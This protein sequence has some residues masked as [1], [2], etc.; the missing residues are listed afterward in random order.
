LFRFA[1][2][3]Y[4]NAFNL[5]LPATTTTAYVCVYKTDNR[6]RDMTGNV[7]VS[8]VA[9]A[10]HTNRPVKLLLVSGRSRCLFLCSRSCVCVCV[11]VYHNSIIIIYIYVLIY[12]YL[13]AHS[14]TRLLDARV[15]LSVVFIWRVVDGVGGVG[16]GV[17]NAR[18][19]RVCL[20]FV[21]FI[22]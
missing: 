16:V 7:C 18:A 12:L 1:R 15:I 2:S 14:L 19:H 8:C 11:C 5:S 10:L 22:I 3:R 9:F 21:L 4:H 20:R 17:C 6:R 13:F